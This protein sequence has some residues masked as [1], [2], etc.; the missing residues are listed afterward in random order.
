MMFCLSREGG[1]AGFMLSLGQG[2]GVCCP[3][4]S[5]RS[6]PVYR[7]H[8]SVMGQVPTCKAHSGPA[9]KTNQVLKPSLS[10]D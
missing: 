8:G 7:K 3:V 5:F 10:A 6:D 4:L 2:N 9:R 1:G